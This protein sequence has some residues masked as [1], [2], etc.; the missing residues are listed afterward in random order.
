MTA[1]WEQRHQCDEMTT[2]RG[3]AQ[4]ERFALHYMES[5]DLYLCEQHYQKRRTDHRLRT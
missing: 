5:D 1:V 3:L 4:C 2:Y